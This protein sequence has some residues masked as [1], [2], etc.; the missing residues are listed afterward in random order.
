MV[1][2]GLSLI[3]TIFLVISIFIV[4]SSTSANIPS[5][6]DLHTILNFLEHIIKPYVE[7]FKN[8][9]ETS[10]KTVK[11]TV[12]EEIIKRIYELAPFLQDNDEN[13]NININDSNDET[14]ILEFV[15]NGH[16]N[17]NN[18]LSR[19][20]PYQ[21]DLEKYRNMRQKIQE[22]LTDESVSKKT[23]HMVTKTMDQMIAQLIG[24]KCTWKSSSNKEMFRVNQGISNSIDSSYWKTQFWK[25][26]S[27]L[28]NSLRSSKDEDVSKEKLY[29][30][31]EKF[32]NY[33]SDIIK[34]SDSISDRYKI[35]CKVIDTEN[36]KNTK[37]LRQNIH[38]TK[39][40]KH[41][42]CDNFKICSKELD[43]FM[44]D[45]YKLLN[46]TVVSIFRNYAEMYKKDVNNDDLSEKTHVVAVINNMSSFTED[47][48][49]IMY[50]KEIS[51]FEPD[52]LKDKKINIK[53]IKSFV[54]KI[55]SNTNV[56]I[57]K[58]LKK[59]ITPFRGS[60]QISLQKD[61]E[62]NLDTDL[63]R[64]KADV[65]K[66]ICPKFSTCNGKDAE[67]RTNIISKSKDI[68][69]N[70]VY[71]KIEMTMNE[72]N[73]SQ[74]EL[75]NGR[76]IKPDNYTTNKKNIKRII[77]RNMH[78]SL[79]FNNNKFNVTGTTHPIKHTTSKSFNNGSHSMP[80]SFI[81]NIP[82]IVVETFDNQRKLNKTR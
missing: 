68:N 15:F 6:A 79:D 76:N 3:K 17:V 54:K 57:K 37:A 34:Q 7:N 47:R 78:E 72:P 82:G 70:S 21:T 71:V 8:S 55:L 31:F 49:N 45:F 66:K 16:K 46:D 2:I 58:S 80:A 1:H 25:L 38:Y 18:S 43:L 53:I 20:D 5:T 59:V 28:L 56:H 64:I 73:S 29:S 42:A 69:K 14:T 32:R 24:N 10:F 33:F 44:S 60:L 9:Q 81:M 30:F 52:K 67:R 51:K 22:A 77:H 23:Q 50:K 75:L 40:N 11:Y 41:N 61:L 39:I 48:L 19:K 13:E 27:Y 63:D 4:I 65:I 26:K 74:T 35:V 12:K 62:H 36:N